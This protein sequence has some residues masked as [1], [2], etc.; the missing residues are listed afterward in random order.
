M[1]QGSI[2]R[3]C[4]IGCDR[5]RDGD[6]CNDDLSGEDR[7]DEERPAFSRSECR[8]RPRDDA[9]NEISSSSH[10]DDYTALV[11]GSHAA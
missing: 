2:F 9:G 7:G 11:A 5:H 10:H 8:R 3:R 1:L 4:E 6:D